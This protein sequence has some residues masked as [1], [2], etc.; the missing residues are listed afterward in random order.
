M[1][2]ERVGHN[3]TERSGWMGYAFVDVHRISRYVSGI[4]DGGASAGSHQY[5]HPATDL[6]TRPNSNAYFP[7]GNRDQ[8]SESDSDSCSSRPLPLVEIGTRR[9]GTL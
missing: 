7:N 9:Q 3:R 2:H 4:R 8:H 1:G 6:D 5:A